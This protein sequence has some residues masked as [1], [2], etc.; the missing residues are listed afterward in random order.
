MRS[1]RRSVLEELR[2]ERRRRARVLPAAH[3]DGDPLS[4]DEVDLGSELALHPPLDEIEEM[5]AA[6]VLPAVPEPLDGGG[7]TSVARHADRI[8]A[9]A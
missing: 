1:L 4:A 6:Q 8:G 2:E 7:A 5:R 9:E 3:P